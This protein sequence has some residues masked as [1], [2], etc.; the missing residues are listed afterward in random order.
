MKHLGNIDKRRKI[1]LRKVY[2]IQND[3]CT[4]RHFLQEIV[5]KHSVQKRKVYVLTFLLVRLPL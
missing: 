5:G 1:N 4:E 2:D 3:T